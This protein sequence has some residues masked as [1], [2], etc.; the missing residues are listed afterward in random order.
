MFVLTNYPSGGGTAENEFYIE[1]EPFRTIDP[2]SG[3]YFLLKL[4][5]VMTNSTYY[6][7]PGYNNG[8]STN[9]DR[10]SKLDITLT[11]SPLGTSAVDL[12]R[13]EGF[14]EWTLYE[15]TSSSNLDPT[16]SSVKGTLNSGMCFLKN[17]TSEVS[18]TEYDTTISN[19]VYN[20]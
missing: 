7:L 8:A 4:T 1:T 15:Q 14:F 2:V 9:N 6:V 20:G 11:N 10:F 17:P 5:S 16:D 19:T 18:F 12:K 3:R 13:T